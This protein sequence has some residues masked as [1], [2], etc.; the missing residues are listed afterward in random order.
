MSAPTLE[1]D[2]LADITLAENVEVI[3]HPDGAMSVVI[4]GRDFPWAIAKNPPMQLVRPNDERPLPVLMVPVL[5][6]RIEVRDAEPEPEVLEG[7]VV[8]H[9]GGDE[10]P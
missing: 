9:P 6:N 10:T 2:H 1:H 8:H 7:E 4:D 5:C 3:L